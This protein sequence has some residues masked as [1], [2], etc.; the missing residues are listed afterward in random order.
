M[1]PLKTR[2]SPRASIPYSLTG[3]DSTDGASAGE[4]RSGHESGPRR[5]GSAGGAR[6]CRLRRGE[7][8]DRGQDEFHHRHEH[9]RAGTGRARVFPPWRQGA[10]GPARDSDGGRRGRG[11]PGVGPGSKRG[12]AAVDGVPPGADFSG[13]RIDEGVA[14][15]DLP[16]T[17][18]RSAV[19]QVVYTLTQFPTVQAAEI[20]G[21]RYTRADF[22]DETPQILV[23]SPLPFQTVRSPLRAS[24]TANTFEATF[25]YELV[26]PQGTILAQSFV[27]ASSGSGERGT[28]SF[29]VP[30]S[31]TRSGL[32]KL[33]VFEVSAED[34]SRIHEIAIPIRLEAA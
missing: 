27:T 22:E 30:F 20:R 33:V 25:Q 32:G 13:L 15:L 16:P 24:G 10:A 8:D 2:T 26:D 11:A 12:G 5:R 17:W 6:P 1:P 19:A 34:G 4:V 29:E 9:G 7:A 3:L 21:Q 23:E 28:F 31:A 14:S 18:E